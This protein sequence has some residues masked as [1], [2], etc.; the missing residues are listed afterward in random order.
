MLV[1]IARDREIRL[2]NIAVALNLT[3]GWVFGIVS[4]LAAGGWVVKEKA[5]RRTH[6]LIQLDVRLSEMV[7]RE[8]TIGEVLELLVESPDA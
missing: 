5:G 2:R 1:C 4:E 7:T 8:V 3:E 6:Y